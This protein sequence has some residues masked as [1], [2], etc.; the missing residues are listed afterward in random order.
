MDSLWPRDQANR[1]ISRAD[2]CLSGS[3]DLFEDIDPCT[4]TA[5]V[6]T[7][8]CT[9]YSLILESDSGVFLRREMKMGGNNAENVVS[10]YLT[11][12]VTIV[13]TSII[14]LSMFLGALL[15]STLI[16]GFKVL[17]SFFFLLCI[18]IG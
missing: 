5:M 12:I 3:V 2:E 13:L 7:K 8:S 9:L 15:A 6:T 10:K 17:S 11:I 1:I 4:V 14:S 18:D 16:I